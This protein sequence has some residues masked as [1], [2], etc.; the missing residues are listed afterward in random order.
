[1]GE[2]VEEKAG[3]E[4][5]RIESSIRSSRIGVIVFPCIYSAASIVFLYL[6]ILNRGVTNIVLFFVL[7]FLASVSLHGYRLRISNLR[8]KR[9]NLQ[10]QIGADSSQG[11]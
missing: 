9:E 5:A 1:M 11:N 4:L 8:V 7:V 3:E 10:K 6:F 2:L